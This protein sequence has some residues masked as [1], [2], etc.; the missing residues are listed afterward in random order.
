MDDIERALVG[1]LPQF[2]I[3]HERDEERP[4]GHCAFAT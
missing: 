2:Q 4:C 3:H 1:G